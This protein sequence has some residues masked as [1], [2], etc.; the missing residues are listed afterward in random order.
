M[1]AHLK[2]TFCN[3]GFQR[4]VWFSKLQIFHSSNE[5]NTLWWQP[6]LVDRWVTLII[7]HQPWLPAWNTNKPRQTKSI[8]CVTWICHAFVARIFHVYIS[9]RDFAC[10]LYIFVAG[11]VHVHVFLAGI[12]HGHICCRDFSCIYLFQGFC[13]LNFFISIYHIR[14]AKDW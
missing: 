14:R 12:F 7:N 8:G 4:A 1:L 3:S 13:K 6:W 2:I 10:T 5:R 11:I 9:C